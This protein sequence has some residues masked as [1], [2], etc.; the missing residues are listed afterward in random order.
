M[1]ESWDGAPTYMEDESESV[2]VVIG[3]LRSVPIDQEKWLKEQ[4]AD[5]VAMQKASCCDDNF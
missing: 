3:A 5:R 1:S 2:S 4:R